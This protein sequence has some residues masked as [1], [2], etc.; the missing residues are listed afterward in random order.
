MTAISPV[1]SRD[2]RIEDP[3]NL[4]IIHPAARALLPLALRLRISANAVSVTGMALGLAAAAAY[5]HWADWRFST[6][7]FLLM[8]GWLVTDGLDGM[9]ARATNSSSAL[10][11]LLDGVCDH[12]VFVSVYCMIA[13]MIGTVEGWALAIVAGAAHAWQSNFYE[14][15]RARFHRRARGDGGEDRPARTG[16]LL[17]RGYE[18]LSR[19]IDGLSAPI[20]E[21]LRGARAPEALGQAYG[22]CAAAPLKLQSLLSANVRVLAIYVACLLGNPRFFWWFEIA[23]LTAV[24][25]IGLLWHRQTISSLLAP[26]TAGAGT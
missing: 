8:V 19:S 20:D 21:A 13:F 2:A 26:A 10:G 3:S 5:T 1:G 15:E 25:I 17:D 4:L 14:S 7:G 9:V 11:R 12:V 24:L 6:M 22:A 16:N 18:A 23:P